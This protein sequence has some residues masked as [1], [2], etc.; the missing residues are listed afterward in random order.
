MIISIG[1]RRPDGT[2]RKPRR[3]KEGY[4]PQEEVPLYESKGKQW[5]K[6]KETNPIP[7][8]ARPNGP[9]GVL[10][11]KIGTYDSHYAQPVPPNYIPGLG[12]TEVSINDLIGGTK[13]KNSKK[14]K[15]PASSATNNQ[16]ICFSTEVNPADDLNKSLRRYQSKLSHSVN[17]M[18]SNLFYKTLLNVSQL[19]KLAT[20]PK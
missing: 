8:M 14:K 19:C 3:V 16:G 4:V 10:D 11:M 7:G 17:L 6:A 20:L 18:Y 13:T 15:K 2:W 5:A 9:L 12:P 1:T